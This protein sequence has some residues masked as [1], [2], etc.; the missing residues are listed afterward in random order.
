[1]DMHD[2]LEHMKKSLPKNISEKLNYSVESLD[3]LEQWILEQYLTV[4]DIIPQKEAHTVD[5]Y[6]RYV[7]ETFRRQMDY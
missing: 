7:G 2:A 6:A 5:G 3:I 1:M 4:N